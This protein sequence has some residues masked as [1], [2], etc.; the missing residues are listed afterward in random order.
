MS[1]TNPAEPDSALKSRKRPDQPLHAAQIDDALLRLR[2]VE[3]ITGLARSTIYAR[4]KGDEGGFPQPV[5]LSSRCTR[6]RARDVQ[7]WLAAQG[8]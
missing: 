1:T 4:L 7:A 8:R 3:A 6:W 5:R 2:T